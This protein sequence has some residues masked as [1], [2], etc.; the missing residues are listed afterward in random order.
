MEIK[1]KYNIGDKVWLMLNNEP[2][3]AEIECLEINV[4]RGVEDPKTDIIIEYG[5]VRYP[6]RRFDECDLLPS[7]EELKNDL[8]GNE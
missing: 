8:F 7:K 5:L 4:T 6:D 3:Q 1:T 2:I